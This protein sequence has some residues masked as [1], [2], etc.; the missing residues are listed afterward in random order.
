MILLVN[1]VKIICCFYFKLIYLFSDTFFKNVISNMDY[2]AKKN[3]KLRYV[4]KHFI[5]PK[6]KSNIWGP[7]NKKQNLRNY[8]L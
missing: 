2:F 1:L 4:T 5:V 3:K 6:L 8:H 7:L